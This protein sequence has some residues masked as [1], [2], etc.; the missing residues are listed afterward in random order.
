MGEG[1]T[2]L[3]VA[4]VS[5]GASVPALRSVSIARGAARRQPASS[6]ATGRG[7]AL[8]VAKAPVTAATTRAAARWGVERT[9]A[10]SARTRSGS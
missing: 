8:S 7:A 2:P 10:A 5:V 9:S 1:V 6:R 3:L 4:G